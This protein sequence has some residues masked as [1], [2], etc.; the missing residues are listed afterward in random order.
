M[1]TCSVKCVQMCVYVCS[2]ADVSEA[3]L[4]LH[5][6]EKQIQHPTAAMIARSATAQVFVCFFA[7]VF[8]ATAS[9]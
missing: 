8:H 1:Q 4:L 3:D 2:A 7:D 6:H 9:A 5:G